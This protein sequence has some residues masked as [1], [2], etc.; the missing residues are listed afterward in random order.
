MMRTEAS[1]RLAMDNDELVMHYQPVVDLTRGTVVGVEALIRWQ[2]P[3]DGL[4]G[5]DHFIPV[6]EAGG[7]IVPLG[8]WVLEQAA[9]QAVRWHAAGLDL[10]MAVNVSTRQVA[11]RDLVPTLARVLDETG[12]DPHHLV[13]EVTESAVMEDAE[14]AATVLKAIIKLGV[15]LSIDD[16]GTGYS[17]LVYLKR[18][19]IR[20]LKI[21]R[22]FTAGMGIYAEDDA[23][24]AS[25]IGLAKAVGGSCIAE[26]IETEEQFVALRNLRCGFGQGWLFGRA[27]PAQELPGLIA[28]CETKLAALQVKFP[29][30]NEHRGQ[31]ADERDHVGDDRDQMGD[32]RDSVS[33][34]RDHTADA[35]DHTADDRDQV[36]DQRDRAA[37]ERD[38]AA[39]ERDRAA[40]NRDQASN[41]RGGAGDR[42]KPGVVAEPTLE[43]LSIPELV[44]RKAALT[45]A[46]ASEDR[47]EGAGGRTQ[48]GLDRDA[49]QT[50]RGVG[51]GGRTQAG[52]DRDAAQTVRGVGAGG[53]T[54]AGLDRDAAQTVRGVG[55]SGRTQAGLD[56]DT[57]HSDRDSSAKDEDAFFDPRTGVYFT[58]ASL[59]QLE[60]EIARA[61]LTQQ[62][63]VLALIDIDRLKVPDHAGDHAAGDRMLLGVAKALGASVRSYDLL[64]RS[65][66]DA[67]AWALSGLKMATV[68]KRL[69]IV[70]AAL[71]DAP[72]PG[73][74]RF[75]IAEL[76]PDDLPHDVVERANAALHL[77]AR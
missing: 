42:R 8:A 45:R 32:Q 28:L 35:R 50:V 4:I 66:G 12:V 58:K 17:S 75:G 56:R 31:T 38:R 44:R 25:V 19:P 71:A 13:L 63:L 77:T 62:P 15:S 11:H 40:D 24:V 73:L 33:D 48:A 27:V 10:D 20:A 61:R 51:A 1:L 53:R 9:T 34:A 16:F 23:I 55:A 22:S 49:A 46:R 52:L 18:Y 30:E 39:D 3:T 14:A 64:H 72:E 29:A 36:G 47:Q 6:A 5:P 43:N 59:V 65:G 69:A 37:D 68:K 7:L 54:Q 26:G 57:A 60:R 2:H 21:D 74:V 76:R 41:R 67:F 70:N